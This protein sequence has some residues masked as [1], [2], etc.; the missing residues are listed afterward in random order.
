MRSLLSTVS[1]SA[2]TLALAACA[3]TDAPMAEVESEEAVAVAEATEE[4]A[5]AAE[6]ARIAAE[7]LAARE[8]SDEPRAMLAAGFKDAE[9]ASW[10]MEMV[11]AVPHPP[12]FDTQILMDAFLSGQQPSGNFAMTDLAF[13]GDWVIEGNFHGFNIHDVSDEMNPETVLSV[14]CPGGQGDVGIYGNLLFRSIEGGN[15]RL[16]CGTGG[17]ANEASDERFLGVQIFDISDMNNP[18]QVAAVQT[19]RGSHTHTIVPDKN[20]PDNIYIYNSGLRGS[21]SEEELSICVDDRE[22]QDPNSAYFSIDVIKVPLNNPEDSEI[23][24]SPRIFADEDGNIAGLWDGGNHGEGTQSTSTTTGCHDITVYPHFDIAA[25]ACSGNG[26]IMDISD[27]ANPTRV[28]AM[29][30]ENFAFWH[31]A[32]FTNDADA[33]VFGDE[34][35]GGGQARCRPSDPETWGASMITDLA[36]DGSMEAISYFKIPSF[37]SDTENCVAHNGNLVPVPG[38]DIMV[39]SWYQGGISVF[40][41]TDRENPFEIAYFDKGPMPS[42]INFGG[43]WSSYWHNGRIY[44]T[45]ILRGLE[46]F[47]LEPSEFLTEAEIAAAELVMFEEEN[48]QT[49]EHIVW[50]QS[51]VVAQAYLDQLV[52]E[53]AI[54]ADLAAGL[55][56]IIDGEAGDDTQSI[57]MGLMG[58]MSEAD[59][60]NAARLDGAMRALGLH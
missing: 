28:S 16:D 14:V 33:I 21:R 43:Y 56:A 13:Q 20:D 24:D 4:T 40:D 41:F 44:G 60:R 46:I 37:Q 50:P 39:Q 3:T 22:G 35:G 38:R 49:Q 10:N 30:S 7:N 19:C 58:A 34:W 54:S 52:R 29:E 27:P 2:F 31:N 12:A 23:I 9:V 25:G 57:H 53:D 11:T 15:G 45:D 6:Q 32:T 8:A 59:A 36:T 17:N 51:P 55:Q 42:G 26:I 5:R 47:K 1:I 48:P 18:V